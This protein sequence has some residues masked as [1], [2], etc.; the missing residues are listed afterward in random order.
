MNISD[1]YGGLGN[2]F[3]Q[4]TPLEISSRFT[5]AASEQ[6]MQQAAQQQWTMT[7]MQSFGPFMLP[8]GLYTTAEASTASTFTQDTIILKY[9]NYQDGIIDVVVDVEAEPT[10][11]II[12]LTFPDFRIIHRIEPVGADSFFLSSIPGNLP[13]ASSLIRNCRLLHLDS[14]TI[15]NKMNYDMRIE[16]V[17]RT[18]RRMRQENDNKMEP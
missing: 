16:I 1:M 12:Q 10:V 11:E 14:S 17:R 13:Y 6:T 4:N 15:C 7:M 18:A 5:R 2:I 3:N 8:S 9:L